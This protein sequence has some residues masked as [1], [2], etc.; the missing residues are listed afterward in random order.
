MTVREVAAATGM[1][2]ACIRD[3]ILRRRM[4]YIKMGRC[5]RFR[6]EVIEQ[7]IERGTVLPRR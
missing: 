1:T 6:P 7:L 5:I 2:E 4:E 3:W